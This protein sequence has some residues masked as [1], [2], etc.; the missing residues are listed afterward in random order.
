VTQEVP[1]REAVTGD[2]EFRITPGG[3]PHVVCV[4][5]RELGSD[6]ELRFWRDDLL[7]MRTPP[8]DTEQDVFVAFYASAE[9]ACFLQLGWK[10]PRHVIYSSSTAA[11]PMAGS[12]S[13]SG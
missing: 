10:L 4:V 3:L 7:R 2:F 12:S 8:F 6:R 9:I 13:T 1:F 5:F 11:S